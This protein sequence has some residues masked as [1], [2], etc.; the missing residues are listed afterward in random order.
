MRYV[1][2]T[3]KKALISAVP[4][5]TTA[6]KWDA[7]LCYSVGLHKRFSSHQTGGRRTTG[8]RTN[9]AARLTGTMEE[10]E[11]TQHRHPASPTVFSLHLTSFG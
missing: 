8:Q 5:Q 7:A 11:P 6:L 9:A 10:G 4:C 1:H 3:Q 2:M